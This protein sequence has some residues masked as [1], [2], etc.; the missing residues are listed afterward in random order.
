[1]GRRRGFLPPALCQQCGKPPD[2]G[3]HLWPGEQWRCT[4]CMEGHLPGKDTLSK[5]M[6][7][8][9]EYAGG[10]K[11]AF[12]LEDKGLKAE[13]PRN[14][15]EWARMMSAEITKQATARAEQI[16]QTKGEAPPPPDGKLLY[17]TMAVPDLIA[18]DAWKERSQLL[19]QYGGDVAAMAQDASASI[20]AENS[21]E[22]M[23]AH[24]LAVAHK[25]VMELIGRAR[26]ASGSDAELKRLNLATRFMAVFQQG[27]LTLKK[28]RQSGQQKITVQYVNVSDGG[29]AVIGDVERNKR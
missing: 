28:I 21:L 5:S 9:L 22:Q 27:M 7:Q 4:T 2:L 10:M 1:M 23:M 14:R 29:Q 24:E 3:R 12:D 11:E 20:K 19:L 18:V 6:N 17:D 16:A 15:A 25:L 13:E 8:M 26:G